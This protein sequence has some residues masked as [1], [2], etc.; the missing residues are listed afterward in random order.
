MKS[1]GRGILVGSGLAIFCL[2]LLLAL[3]PQ[4]YIPQRFT[5]FLL[6]NGK[7][8]GE[9]VR[10]KP[11]D[12]AKPDLPA[13][14]RIKMDT[15]VCRAS[16]QR[17][18]EQTGL[19]S[20]G[21]GNCHTR[22]LASQ[23]LLLDPQGHSG[24]YD[25][26]IGPQWHPLTPRARRLVLLPLAISMFLVAALAGRLTPVLARV[27][28][29]R[30]LF[31]VGIAVLSGLVLYPMAHEGGHMLFGIL[32]GAVPDWRGVVWT[33]LTGEEPHGSFR[34]LPEGASPMMS[35]GGHLLPTALALLLLVV[36]RLT[37]R[38]APWSI[39]ALLVALPVLFLLSSFGCLFELYQNTHMDA[40]AVHFGLTGAARVLVSLGPLLLALA[41][42]G[43]LAMR[44]WK[45]RQRSP[46]QA[47]A[48]AV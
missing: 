8:A 38:K 46:A 2:I 3:V 35:A 15:G 26:F 1:T 44:W 25:V 41:A 21:E 7:F 29:A 28:P 32:F 5:P 12:T 18:S 24:Q 22:V 31:L 47:P 10:F 9:P 40:L 6:A 30:F 36:W 48:K 14:I 16:L 42:Y 43:W 39:S 27:R 11:P 19:F 20:T 13:V 33:M 23:V 17:G 45:S 4:R 37:C 34:Y